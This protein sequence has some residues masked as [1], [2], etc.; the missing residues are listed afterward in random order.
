MSDDSLDE[1]LPTPDE[2][3]IARNDRIREVVKE[4]LITIAV[5]LRN[6]YSSE[7]SIRVN[8]TAP[9]DANPKIVTE[10]MG[11]VD[12]RCRRRGWVIT[13]SSSNPTFFAVSRN[14]L[15]QG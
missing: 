5:E 14:N 15:G 7:P 10:V 9:L 1:I 11:E 13:K 4:C 2:L 12:E 6:S 8:L 3:E